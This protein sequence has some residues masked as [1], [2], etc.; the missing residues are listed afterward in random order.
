MS[1]ED[2]RMTVVVSMAV[3]LC[4]V[5]D[6]ESTWER[7]QL[8]LREANMSLQ[9]AHPLNKELGNNTQRMSDGT[10]PA[11]GRISAMKLFIIFSFY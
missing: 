6:T 2:E 11:H 7:A 9:P 5:I 3:G 10:S 8:F 4:R 1:R